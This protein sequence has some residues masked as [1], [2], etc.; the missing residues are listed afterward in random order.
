MRTF[1]LLAGLGRIQCPTL[2]LAGEDYPILPI[3]DSEDIAR[4]IPSHLVRLERFPDAGH[5]V[6]RDGPDRALQIIR[7]FITS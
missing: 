6:F 2:I 5:G 7:D 3:E 1:N 4:A